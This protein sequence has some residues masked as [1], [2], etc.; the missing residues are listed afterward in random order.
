M[1]TRL[2][3]FLKFFLLLRTQSSWFETPPNTYQTCCLG[4]FRARHFLTC[5]LLLP[6]TT[7][8]KWDITLIEIINTAM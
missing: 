7:L 6:T 5:T 8:D 3:F 1:K 4:N 2:L